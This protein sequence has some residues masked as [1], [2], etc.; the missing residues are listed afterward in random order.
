M[1]NWITQQEGIID[2]SKLA[3]FQGTQPARVLLP[4]VV[5]LFQHTNKDFFREIEKMT[6]SG[7]LDPRLDMQYG[8]VGLS[9][10]A[11]AGRGYWT[12][13]IINA[14]RTIQLHETFLSYQWCICYAIFV[15]FLETIDFPMMN[16]I[17]GYDKYLVSAEELE[18]AL[19]MFD[20]GRQ[21]IVYYDPWNK[22]EMPNPERYMAEK[23]DFIEQTNIFF[24]ESMK[25]ILGH[26]VI[27]AKKHLPNL[28][29]PACDDCYKDMEYEADLE[30][31][32]LILSGT[33]ADRRFIVEIGIVLG[34]LSMFYFAGETSGKRHPRVED[35]LG[36]A[37]AR[38]NIAPDSQV[39]GFACVGL[40]LWDRQFNHAFDWAGKGQVSYQEM[41]ERI[42]GQIKV[43][44]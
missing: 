12:P 6:Q 22:D 30:A 11:T 32:D 25:F 42:V 38:L 18:R 3:T 28:P 35:R 13:K 33:S 5:H 2:H 41:F 26:E 27:H 29:D 14:T 31:I 9:M 10:A 34:L 17:A 36:H 37:I 15:V 39:W 20:Y 8:E 43:R 21:L 16:E 1:A 23:R 44:H 7:L 4:M 40:E 19:G 24:T